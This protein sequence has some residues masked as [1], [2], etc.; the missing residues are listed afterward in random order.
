MYKILLKSDIGNRS[1]IDQKFRER[2]DSDMEYCGFDKDLQKGFLFF[3]GASMNYGIN[4]TIVDVSSHFEDETTQEKNLTR[5]IN[6]YSA[7]K[8]DFEHYGSLNDYSLMKIIYSYNIVL[9]KILGSDKPID[10]FL[11]TT[12]TQHVTIGKTDLDDSLVEKFQDEKFNINTIHNL[13]KTLFKTL[14]GYMTEAGL[15]KKKSYE[16]GYAYFCMM[17]FMDVK[18]TNFLLANIHNYLSPLFDALIQYPI[19]HLFYSKELEANHILTN[20]LEM[21]YKGIDQKVIR[22]IRHFHQ[23]LFYKEESTK[24]RDQWNFKEL[25]RGL[26][27]SQVLHNS[28]GFRTFGGAL[29]YRQDFLNFNDYYVSKLKNQTIDRQE[30]FDY[31]VLILRQKYNFDIDDV[32]NQGNTGDFMQF[33][34]IIFYETCMHAMILQKVELVK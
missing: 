13:N 26:L 6:L 15:G 29:R 1:L 8:G 2:L 18:G 4:N 30:L 12:A 20:I 9:F 10:S 24:I 7:P 28:V 14:G 21:F 22:P 11:R 33:L 27:L 19:L 5:L 16:A 34:V 25:E 17:S 31:I 32:L 3:L 23:V